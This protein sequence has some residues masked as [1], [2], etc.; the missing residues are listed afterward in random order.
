M[1]LRML[2][3][4]LVAKQTMAVN[5]RT[6]SAGAGQPLDVPDFDGEILGANSWV[7]VAPSGPTSARP[8]GALGSGLY[9]ASEG[10]K[11]FD[12]TLNYL[13]IFA[14]GAWRNPATGASV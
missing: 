4:L 1:N 2:G 5:G 9:A 12:T 6:Y 3:P 8:T 11:Y 13:V 10:Q 14:G 7:T